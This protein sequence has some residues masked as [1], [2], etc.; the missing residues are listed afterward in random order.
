MKSR[1]K[2]LNEGGEGGGYASKYPIRVPSSADRWKG[3][4]R[5]VGRVKCAASPDRGTFGIK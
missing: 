5:G 2:D 3:V 4:G 1:V